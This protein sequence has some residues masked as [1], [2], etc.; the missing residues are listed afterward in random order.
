M[1]ILHLHSRESVPFHCEPVFIIANLEE[2]SNIYWSVHRCACIVYSSSI[3]LHIVILTNLFAECTFNAISKLRPIWERE[4]WLIDPTA[5]SAGVSGVRL[6]EMISW[7]GTG[8]SLL[9]GQDPSV[10]WAD[11]C[12]CCC[13]WSGLQGRPV[14]NSQARVQQK[15]AITDITTRHTTV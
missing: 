11:Y 10:N 9:W 8:L 15:T 5:S 2:A 7:D 12:C 3:K 4:W 13:C 6:L 1:Y 14:I